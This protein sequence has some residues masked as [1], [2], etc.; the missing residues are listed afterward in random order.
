M[1]AAPRWIAPTGLQT[2]RIPHPGLREYA[3]PRAV[4]GAGPS[5][6][7]GSGAPVALP[8][9]IKKLMRTRKTG[10]P[11]GRV[12]YRGM[13]ILPMPRFGAAPVIF[14]ISCPGKW[15]HISFVNLSEI[16]LR[17]NPSAGGAC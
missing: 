8:Q 9:V 3:P 16:A 11:K 1:P 12:I 10:N 4:A 2:S 13:G 14:G 7:G 5:G 17:V 15:M 6:L